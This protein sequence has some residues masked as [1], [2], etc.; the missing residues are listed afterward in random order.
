MSST[1]F[2]ACMGAFIGALVVIYMAQARFVRVV[3]SAA[4]FF[5][6]NEPVSTSRRWQFGIP[7]LTRSFFAQLAALL[8]LLI[9]GLAAQLH[10]PPEQQ[11]R[12]GIWILV[13]RSASM[14]TVQNGR[15][16]MDAA[17]DAIRRV[18][19]RANRRSVA[20]APCFKLSAFDLALEDFPA[21]RYD[22][23]ELLR[24]AS[25]IEPR[26]L[27]T[28]LGLVQQAAQSSVAGQAPG[29]RITHVVVVSDTPAPPWVA[30]HGLDWLDISQRTGNIGL[31]EISSTRDLF[32]GK[33]ERVQLQVE[34]FG[35]M[36]EGS[37]LTVKAPDGT[38]KLEQEFLPGAEQSWTLQF[39]P[40]TPGAY[41]IDIAPG[42]AYRFDDHAEIDIPPAS[43][44]RVDWRAGRRD[45][46]A[47]LG[48]EQ[49]R[50]DP[51]LTV[52]PAD[53]ADGV[54]P[55]I[56]V[57]NGFRRRPPPAV[58][59]WA[60]WETSP[61]LNS[62]NLDVGERIGMQ[63]GNLPE[64]FTPVLTGEGGPIWIAQRS[65]PPAAYIPG[66]PLEG[67]DA[68]ARF[69]TTLFFNAA[70]W[71]LE[72]RG[73]TPLF[74]LTSPREPQPK[75]SL[76]AL[77]PGEGNT[78]RAPVSYGSLDF[79]SNTAAAGAVRQHSAWPFLVLAALAVFLFERRQAFFGGHRWS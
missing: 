20:A 70:R 7:R 6:N 42:G 44:V 71:I 2:I 26:P 73:Y 31:T 54:G 17:K 40:D 4:R 46:L 77:H 37:R 11:R 64:A 16:R 13:D 79:P 76:L 10:A 30:D 38:V 1:T 15:A 56:L 45:L 48:W 58:P 62:L 35:G 69:S 9:A 65:S 59:F 55:A 32:S 27:G 75:G 67:D 21:D 14:S 34:A 78:G 52:T 24:S 61:L 57:G 3:I 43:P 28:D 66:L 33:V 60:F 23:A 51:E 8:L 36:R 19:E 50:T 22:A 12:L 74:R 41:R 49:D 18:V 29:C 47:Q 39:K 72:R 63:G 53:G 5:V 25:G 68:V